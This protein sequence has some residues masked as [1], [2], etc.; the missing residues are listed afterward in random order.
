M[1]TSTDTESCKKIVVI[2]DEGYDACFTGRGEDKTATGP[3]QICSLPV[4]NLFVC[5]LGPREK[6]SKSVLSQPAARARSPR[7]VLVVVPTR[8]PG[9]GIFASSPWSGLS[10]AEVVFEDFSSLYTYDHSHLKFTHRKAVKR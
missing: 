8:P 4:V 1:S 6:R 3:T 5:L 9:C 7:C 2:A 10:A